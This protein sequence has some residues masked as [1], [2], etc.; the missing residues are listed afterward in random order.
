M[1]SSIPLR[2]S[3]NTIWFLCILKVINTYQWFFFFF[4]VMLLLLKGSNL[5]VKYFA[6]MDLKVHMASFF[7]SCIL[8]V[9]IPELQNTHSRTTDSVGKG[10]STAWNTKKS[11]LVELC[12]C[13]MQKRRT[14]PPTSQIEHSGSIS[15]TVAANDSVEQ[16]WI[17]HWIYFFF[18]SSTNSHKT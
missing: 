1:K 13:C 7:L 12:I 4:F 5:F 16:C 17:Q 2:W 11:Y 10:F 14:P 6:I 3:Q 8:Q 18:Y 15:S 9:G